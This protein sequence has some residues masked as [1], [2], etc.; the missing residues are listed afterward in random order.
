LTAVH[1]YPFPDSPDFEPTEVAEI[2]CAHCGAN[3]SSANSALQARDISFGDYFV[4]GRPVFLTGEGHRLNTWDAGRF[5][6]LAILYHSLLG[7]AKL[8]E[9][10][11][12]FVRNGDDTTA[13][14][15]L[16]WVGPG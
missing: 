11:G 1:R 14:R 6:I 13:T 5:A 16:T 15:I 10:Y 8:Q 3:I 4:P 9:V 2:R 12:S 7:L